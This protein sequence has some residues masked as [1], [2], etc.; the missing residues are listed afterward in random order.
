MFGER[1]GHAPPLT[2]SVLAPG[3]P[4]EFHCVVIRVRF[5]KGHTGARIPLLSLSLLSRCVH[6]QRYRACGD[7]P[8]KE[9]PSPYSVCRSED[10][11]NT[12]QIHTCKGH[13][14]EGRIHVCV[15]V[16]VCACVSMK[17]Y[18][19]CVCVCVSKVVT[20]EVVWIDNFTWDTT[21]TVGTSK[22][23]CHYGQGQRRRKSQGDGFELQ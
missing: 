1:T 6:E 10:S 8:A 4:H 13:S 17:V 21:S 3:S 19:A 14:P 9:P 23:V 2:V 7:I 18:S 5:R 12:H 20:Q 16:C 11:G 22:S 15:C